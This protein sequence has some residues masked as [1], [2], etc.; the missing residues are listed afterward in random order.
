MDAMKTTV[1]NL[2]RPVMIDG[3]GHYTQ[4]ERPQQVNEALVQCL[5]GVAVP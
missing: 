4:Q 2:E 5:R 3:A 1:P